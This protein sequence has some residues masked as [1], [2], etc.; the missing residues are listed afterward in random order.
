M[1]RRSLGAAAALALIACTRSAVP[2]PYVPSGAGAY[3]VVITGGR[4]VD[5]TGNPWYYGDVGIRG[6]RIAVVAPR[7]ALAQATAA[8]RVDAAGLVVAPG[9]ID[10]QGQSDDALT[11]GD[12]R[13]VSKVTQ[14]VTTEILGEGST[15][16]PVNDRLL[17]MMDLRPGDTAARR[18]REQF[19]GE[20]GFGRWLDWM[21]ARGAS[22]NVGSFLGAGTVRA[23]AKGEAEG[24]PT[25]AELD[26][27]RRVVRDAMRDGALGLA[28]ALIYPP[29]SYASTDE[30]VAE[31]QA[32]APY[33][34]LYIT[35][36]RSE[37]DSLLA[38]LAEA[39]AIG[40]RGGVP[41]EIYHLK[42]AAPRNWSKARAMVAMIDSARSAG[43]DVGATM[44]PYSASANGLAACIPDW[45]SADGKLLERL[46]DS[47]LRARIVR[48][49]AD[50]TPG[51]PQYCQDV[52]AAN[53]MLV[54]LRAP[55]DQRFEGE[56]LSEIAQAMGTS[57]P[58]AAIA[59][60]LAEPRQPGKI[61]FSMSDSNVAMQLRQPWVVIGTDAGGTDPDSVHGMTHPRGYGSYPRILG[62]Y[63]RQDSLLTLEDAVRKMTSAVAQRLWVR[64]RGELREGM[65]AD[66]VV[67]DPSTIIDHATYERPLQLS[68]GVRDVLV[69]GVAVVRDGRHTGAKPG[70]AVKGP[71]LATRE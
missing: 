42:A 38:A 21:V 6:D 9:F 22:V 51:Q 14:G 40:R 52:G 62:R 33:H 60:L 26:T 5:G 61:N 34:G 65:Y 57:W 68:T 69:N 17:A 55:D 56:R 31:A 66:V 54:G 11:E 48:E 41:V 64:D 12:S 10:I 18:I 71:G 44:Y 63:V 29:G 2:N 43:Q 19:R 15:P 8:R 16:A 13:L 3:D 49:M 30:L 28:S 53:I 70:K 20:R 1:I 7:G 36:I 27:M 58:E 35:H 4:I 32:M 37:G 46:R 39:L 24:A 45:V 23:Y 67:F 59:L 50:T 47:T 25:P